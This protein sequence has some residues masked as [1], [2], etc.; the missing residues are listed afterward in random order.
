MSRPASYNTKQREAVLSYIASLGG[1]HVTAAQIAAY[2]SGGGAHIGRTTIYRHLDKLTES[3]KIRKYTVDGTS[4]ACFQYIGNTEGCHT[5]LHL[6][7]EGCGELLHL[8][9]DALDEIQRHISD[10]H[11]F[12]VNSVKTVFY[13]KCDNCLK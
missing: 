9:C 3:G 10:E 13:G 1:S 8:R 5:H 4:G 2:F 6:K 11:A 7:C 12:Q